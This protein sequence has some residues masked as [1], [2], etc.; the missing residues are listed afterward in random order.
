MLKKFMCLFMILILAVS[1]VYAGVLPAF[2]DGDFEN[3]NLNG[4]QGVAAAE[5]LNGKITVISENS[6]KY[7]KYYDRKD[8]YSFP[9]IDVTDFL[10]KNGT[11][12]YKAS[13]K[14]KYSYPDGADKSDTTKYEPVKSALVLLRTQSKTSD[15]TGL[16]KASFKALKSFSSPVPETWYDFDVELEITDFTF[17]SGNTYKDPYNAFFG[18]RVDNEN[19]DICVDDVKFEYITEE[20]GLQ[21]ELIDNAAQIKY[22]AKEV[23]SKFGEENAKALALIYSNQ[24]KLI[25]VHINNN[26]STSTSDTETFKINIPS[27]EKAYVK[28]F[29]TNAKDKFNLIY[30]KDI[31]PKQAKLVLIGDSICVDYPLNHSYPIQGWGYYMQDFLNENIQVKNYAH[32]GYSTKTFLEGAGNWNGIL[33]T[34]EKGDYVMVSLGINDSSSNEKYHTDTDK[35]VENLKKFATDTRS[36]GAEIIFITPTPGSWSENNSMQGRS[37]F[38]KQAAKEADVIVL[39]LN[40]RLYDIFKEIGNLDEVRYKYFIPNNYLKDKGMTDEQIANASGNVKTYGYDYTHFNPEGA[41]LLATY[42]F[43]LLKETSSGLN[44]YI[45]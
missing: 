15:I 6:I 26:L 20:K 3:G 22:S 37:E 27:N 33:Q 30:S 21:A 39:D 35:Y 44:A 42:I 8:K 45:K 11:G 7:L 34:L 1:N 14:F 31:G 16:E 40:A 28:L 19:F 38:M 32:G 12:K 9:A 25:G 41:K 36:K 18:I 29:A 10:L 5:S 4:W 23:I 43:E 13:G 2:S 24:N 17:G